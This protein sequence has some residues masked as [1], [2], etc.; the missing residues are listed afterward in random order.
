MDRDA[1]ITQ[2]KNLIVSELNLQRITP[3]DVADERPLFGPDGLGLDSLDALQLGLAI[4]REFAITL[5]PDD[6]DLRPVM[7]SVS[8]LAEF[9]LRA[10]VAS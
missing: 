8:S 10:R 7:T 3:R 6:A 2:L 5:P 4:E 1:V 9:I